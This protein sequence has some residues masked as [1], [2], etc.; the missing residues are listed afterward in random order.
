MKNVISAQLVRY[1]FK[2]LDMISRLLQFLG[3]SILVAGLNF[4]VIW[5]QRRPSFPKKLHFLRQVDTSP[6]CGEGRRK[7]VLK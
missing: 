1:L 2:Y 4:E 3:L 5:V 7:L 6:G